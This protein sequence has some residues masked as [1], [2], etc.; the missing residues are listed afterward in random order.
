MIFLSAIN[1]FKSLIER[2]IDMLDK[3]DSSYELLKIYSNEEL[4]N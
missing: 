1:Q 3:L 2:Y 4:M